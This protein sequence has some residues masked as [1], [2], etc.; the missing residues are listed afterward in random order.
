MAENL[1]M[2]VHRLAERRI[3]YILGALVLGV[4]VLIMPAGP[5]QATAPGANGKIAFDSDRSGEFEVWVM[6]ADGGNPVN[7]SKRPT[8]DDWGP[9]WSPDGFQIAWVGGETTQGVDNWEIFRMSGDGTQQINLTNHV[10]DDTEPSWSPDGTKI[11]FDSDRSGNDDIW[12]MDAD[13][14]NPVNL[15][16]N[17][18]FDSQA[19][20]SP[21]GTKISFGSVRSGVPDVWVMDA[22]GNNP[23]NLTASASEDFSPDW[24]P[25]GLMIAFDS[26]RSGNFDVWTMKPDGS[27]QTQLTTEL[28]NEFFPSWSP[29]GTKILFE[30]DR[31]GSNDIWVMET[32]PGGQT[33]LTSSLAFDELAA[34]QPTH[35]FTDV[36]PGNV[37]HGNIESLAAAGI[38]KGCNPPANDLYCPGSSVTRGQMAAFLVRALGLTDD[39]GGNL[40]TDDDDS[41]FEGDIDRLGTAGITKGCNPPTNDRFCPDS[42]V[43]REQMAAFLV[44]AIGYVDDGGGDL[45]IDDDDSIF[46]GDIDKLGT[47]GVTKGC[48]PPTNDK[49]CPGSVVTRGQMAAFL[50]RAL[51]LPSVP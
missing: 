3:S 33:N 40:F 7:V 24:S 47:A 44:R 18:A 15:T 1:E 2:V 45:F 9:A 14:S 36:P 30:S 34:W 10:A 29:D 22:N 50:A 48:N 20:W 35:T 19:V 6:D 4:A 8:R 27:D 46:E 32:N 17:S 49:Y 26:D 23:V 25:D 5:G 37:F 51:G 31:S 39:G 11:L 13:G 21:D 42:K 16:N 12:V 28:S 43:T 41:I 38:T